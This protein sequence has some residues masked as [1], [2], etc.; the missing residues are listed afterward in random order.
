MARGQA[1]TLEAVVGGLLLLAAVALALQ[2]TVV[3]PLSTSTSSQHLENQQQSMAKGILAAAAEEGA[4]TQA[5][6]YWNASSSQFHG[7]GEAGYYRSDPSTSLD[8]GRMLDRSFN[9][10]GIAYNVYF[11]YRTQGGDSVQRRFVYSGTP[12]DNAVSAS[13]TVV[14][15]DDAHLVDGDGSPNATTADEANSLYL[16][17]A[18]AGPGTDNPVYNVVEVEVVVW[19][20]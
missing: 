5:V 10:Q 4:L 11:D 2:M 15:V 20:I 18:N 14:V 13:R 6:L 1:F 19:R 8:F 7:V 17:D 9:S 12:S 16:K 3:T